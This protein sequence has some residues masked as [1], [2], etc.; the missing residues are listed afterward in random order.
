MASSTEDT[1]A[2]AEEQLIGALKQKLQDMKDDF[3]KDSTTLRRY[4]I[5]RNWNIK[6]AESMLRATV[7]WRKENQ[8]WRQ[9]CL[10]CYEQPGYH[11]WR[12]VGM[13][14]R[15]RPVI[16]SCFSQSPV[17][18]YTVD[19]S[20][21]HLMYLMENA[22]R[23]LPPTEYQWIWLLDCTGMPTSAYTNPKVGYTA[24]QI[25]SNHYPER[26]GM[27]IIFNYDTIFEGIFKTLRFFLHSNTVGKVHLHRNMNKIETLFRELFD[28]ELVQWVNEEITLN[29]EVP[30]RDTQTNFWNMPSNPADHDPR[31]C[32]TYVNKYLNTHFKEAT[33]VESLVMT[34]APKIKKHRP[35]P[36]ILD[37]LRDRADEAAIEKAEREARQNLE[38]EKDCTIL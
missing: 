18:T 34:M 20:L 13:D 10:Q 26:L 21:K 23:T 16:Y 37:D 33:P 8:P 25:L 7:D 29:K 4:L 1:A 6:D 17:R 27:M 38:E 5:A 28:D 24:F 12:Q 22:Q 32:L 31:G 3:T 14:K 35:H 36:N 9:E 30:L 2:I 11:S 15:G 19:D